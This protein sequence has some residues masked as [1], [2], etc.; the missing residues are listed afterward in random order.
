IPDKY[1]AVMFVPD[2][3]RRR[4]L[5]NL[6]LWVLNT[7]RVQP[8]VIAIEDL[9]WADPSTLELAQTLVEQA[10][11]APLMLLYTARPEFH[12]TWSMRAHHAHATLGRLNDRHTLEMVVGVM[13]QAALAHDLIDPVVKRTDGVPLFAE[14]LTRLVLEGVSRS[15][16]HAIPA[17]LHDSLTARF[18][19]L[20][21]AKD[22]AQVGAV[23]GR[24]FSYELL[25]AVAQMSDAELQSALAKLVDAE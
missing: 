1:S 4:L 15:I 17:T 13:A 9:H 7:T 5:A 19:R 18:D 11:T 3:R 2:Q 16:V 24:E 12:S 22:V 10:P 14:E 8:V 21:P 23:I 6:T 25:Q 20:G